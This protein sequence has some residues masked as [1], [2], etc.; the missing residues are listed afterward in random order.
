MFQLG[1]FQKFDYGS[2]ENKKR[3][4]TSKPP[5]Y[6]LS[7]IRTKVHLLH[8]TNDLLAMDKVKTIFLFDK[9]TN[10]IS[11]LFFHFYAIFT[12]LE[13]PNSDEATSK[14]RSN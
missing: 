14:C 7:N 12:L 8:G 13:H 11:M 3:Y 6:N 10:E 2:G 5:K 9:Q 1:K 4:G